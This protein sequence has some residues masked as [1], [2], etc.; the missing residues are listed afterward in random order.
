MLERGVAKIDLPLVSRTDAKAKG[1]RRDLTP[2]E[3]FAA[4]CEC[5]TMVETKEGYKLAPL[6]SPLDKFLNDTGKLFREGTPSEAMK[7]YQSE[8]T[9]VLGKMAIELEAELKTEAEAA[10][11]KATKKQKASEKRKRA[12]PVKGGKGKQ[13]RGKRRKGKE[14]SAL[15]DSSSESSSDSESEESEE[16]DSEESESEEEEEEAYIDYVL[17]ADIKAALKRSREEAAR[18]PAPVG[19]RRSGRR[20]NQQAELHGL[21]SQKGGVTFN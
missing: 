19:A 5:L 14:V 13:P 3:L 2:E 9:R 20:R 8:E 7:L 12:G 15:K 10:S 16:E 1:G 18:P 21:Q 6:A 4:L 11:A 17:K